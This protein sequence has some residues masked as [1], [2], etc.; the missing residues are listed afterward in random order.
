L[1]RDL[2]EKPLLEMFPRLDVVVE[3]AASMPNRLEVCLQDLVD[4]ALLVPEV[5]IELPLAG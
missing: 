1:Q 3:R 4:E 2:S 5:V